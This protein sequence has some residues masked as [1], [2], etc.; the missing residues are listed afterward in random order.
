GMSYSLQRY[1]GSNPA[2]LAAMADGNRYAAVL[3]AFDAWT[4]SRK[5]TVLYGGRY[6][7]YGY[8]EESLFSPRAQLT[9][10][11][12]AS[13]RLSF[14]ASRRAV[15]PGAEEFVP[16][17]VAG[18]WVPPERT[19]A[20]ITG[21]TFVPERTSHY[22]V[23]VEHDLTPTTVVAARG[24]YQDTEDQLV[25]LFGLGNVERPA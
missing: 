20:P 12:T 15:A 8:L 5:V 3:Y 23:G 17:M 25:T 14:G 21:T 1:D 16:S 19:F 22:D 9:I 2:A 11:P 18:T 4:I 7:K 24:F 6:A 10:A 13:L